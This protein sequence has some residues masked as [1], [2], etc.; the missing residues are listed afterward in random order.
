MRILAQLAVVIL[1]AAGI[2]AWYWSAERGSESA[3]GAGQFR[4]GAR[5]VGVV[6]ATP[7]VDRATIAVEAVG[8]ALA[9][10]AVVVTPK[11]SGIVARIAFSEGARVR[12][13]AVL[14]ELDASELK[15]NLE[16]ERAALKQAR[17]LLERARA[18]YR[19]RAVS[20]A[21]IDQLE[22]E[23]EAAEAR[24]RA[25]EARLQDHVIR[26]PFGGR[27]G[28]RRVSPGAL[29]GPGST[30]TT[31]D[32]TS[33]I[34]VDFR[35]PESVLSLARPGLPIEARSVSYD[36]TFHGV[37]KTLD[38]RVDPATRSIELRTEFPNPDGRLKPGMFLTARIAIDSRDGA[39]LV[40]EEALVA[41]GATHFVF[42]VRDGKAVRTRVR[43]G[44]RLAGEVEIRDGVAATD[45]VVVRGLQKIRDGSAVR[46]IAPGQGA[47]A[48]GTG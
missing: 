45:E 9:N 4:A 41:Q 18:L 21:R 38:S 22:A 5:P 28:L 48:G 15:A 13:G 24:V 8:T 34:K 30:I 36:E 40:P 42:L 17:R 16:E 46:V 47:P 29:V 43:I 35:V 12:A 25:D 3:A 2:G 11:V 20:K 23:L 14:A 39:I 27:L 7:R 19:N 10:E 37:V 44:E 6:V 32:D 33:R 31:L 1:L 26:A